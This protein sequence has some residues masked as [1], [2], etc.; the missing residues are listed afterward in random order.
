MFVNILILIALIAL[1]FLFAWLTVRAVRAKRLWIKIVGG[2]GAG[3]LTL[4][5]IAVAFMGAKGIAVT[6]FSSAAA[7]PDLKVAGTPEQIARGEYTLS[8][9]RASA[10]TA[11]SDPMATRPNNRR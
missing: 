11:Q 5:F 9:C 4:M 1:V 10:A 3:L 6:Y 2:I 7:A 8:A